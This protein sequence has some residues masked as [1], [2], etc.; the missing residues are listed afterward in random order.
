LKP[1][2]L[3]LDTGGT[4]VRFPFAEMPAQSGP[5]RHI[6]YVQTLLRLDQ[7]VRVVVMMTTTS[8]LMIDRIPKGLSVKVS[9]ANSRRLGMRNAFVIDLH[10]LAILPPDKDWILADWFSAHRVD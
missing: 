6:V 2:R 7:L 9:T 4:I 5:I 8:P 1:L 10:R 3:A